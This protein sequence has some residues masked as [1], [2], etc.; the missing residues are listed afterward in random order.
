MP[1]WD[2]TVDFVSVGSG[3]GG[4]MAAI[5][6][7]DAGLSALVV[8]KTPHVGGST[9]MSGGVLWVPANPLMREAGVADSVENGLAHFEAL[10]GDVGAYSSPARREAYIRLGSDVIDTL[11][12]KGVKLI[13]ADGYAD[14]QTNLE[15]G[16]A[17]GRAV[18]CMPFDARQIPEYADK[19]LPGI[20]SMI[21]M[22]VF[23]NELRPMQYVN[24]TVGS[25]LVAA[26]VAIRTMLGKLRRQRLLTNGS[27][28]VAN[29]VK[30]LQGQQVRSGSRRRCT[31]SSWRTA[32]SSASW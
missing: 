15:G 11:R 28:L 2:H 26:R 4:L 6:A 25:F 8:E 22:T 21:G 14:Y 12:A 16:V 7:H 29:M 20:A 5:T 30:I 23:T 18:E 31:S 19:M 27:A 13:Y 17:R 32:S 9:S 1:E 24:R 10:I 3:G